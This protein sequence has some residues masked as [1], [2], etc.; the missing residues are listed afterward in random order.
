MDL[1]KAVEFDWDAAHVNI[2]AVRPGMPETRSAIY[3]STNR[4]Q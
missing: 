1:A 3:G 4:G 2:Q